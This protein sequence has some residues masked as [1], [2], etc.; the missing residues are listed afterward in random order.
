MK[1]NTRITLPYSLCLVLAM[2]AVFILVAAV[3]GGMAY[4]DSRAAR[5]ALAFEVLSDALS[6]AEAELAAQ[7]APAREHV[8]LA[9]RWI[10]QGTLARERV[11]NWS[12]LLLPPLEGRDGV[13]SLA[14][15]TDGGLLWQ[16][17]RRREGWSGRWSPDV[18]FEAPPAETTW[19]AFGRSLR[20]GAG[21]LSE[22]E[23]AYVSALQAFRDRKN[24][25]PDYIH[26]DAQ[27][28]ATGSERVFLAMD[29][30]SSLG[31]PGIIAM[32]LHIPRAVLSERAPEDGRI[33]WQ[34]DPGGKRLACLEESQTRE[35]LTNS[36]VPHHASLALRTLFPAPNGTTGPRWYGARA[37]AVGSDYRWWVVASVGE[38]ALP[39]PSLPVVHY[40]LVGFLVG[41]AGTVGVA[42]TMGW[43]ISRPLSL[44]ARRANGIQ[45]MDEHYLPW[46]NSRFTEVNQLTT[47]LEDLYETA[48]EHLDYHDA[49]LV[50]W[51]Q[52]EELSGT[53][54][55]V[56]AEP[57]K[58]HINLHANG[59]KVPQGADAPSGPVI[60]VSGEVGGVPAVPAA[61]LQ[62]LHG[63]RKEVRRLQSQLAGAYEELRT[64]DVHFQQGEARQKRQREALRELDRQLQ[65]E[66]AVTPETLRILQ[67]V[68]EARVVGFWRLQ[69]DREWFRLRL[70]TDDS[71]DETPLPNHVFLRALL[72]DELVVATRDLAGDPRFAPLREHPRWQHARGAMLLVPLKFGAHVLGFFAIEH[73]RLMG[74]WKGD[75]ETFASSCAIQ[76]TMVLGASLQIKN[77]LPVTPRPSAA[78]EEEG[79]GEGGE[80]EIRW[81]TDL[82]GCFKSIEGN[83]A[84]LLGYTARDLLGQPLTFLSETA[85]G[86]RDLAQLQQALSGAPCTGY[87]TT[88]RTGYGEEIRL[89]V[90]AEVQRDTAGR[91]A[92]IRGT[93]RPVAIPV[94]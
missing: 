80:E 50:V 81:E 3:V 91:V 65:R 52:E 18:D 20:H 55:V 51:G 37:Y 62:V 31:A 54:G 73:G 58:R 77:G 43:K 14:I 69:S 11:E 78:G 30:G 68:L 2:T 46:P 79:L 71:A 94:P 28:M 60:N 8:R 47:A 66:G 6:D 25:N 29:L 86:E 9:Q 42:T 38:S 21:E 32:E 1:R 39:E 88:L 7:I 53:E 57:L 93:A 4:R 40:G 72:Q 41:L 33:T 34:S 24:R 12:T 19:D 44:I 45:S 87:E 48:V 82:A 76:C 22:L 89:Y 35:L 23:G 16:A 36:A 17:S 26:V 90:M 5:S 61:Q 10:L 27:R 70:S 67:S 13:M 56:D 64:A 85:Q 84:A 59:D 92:G 83:V 49:P 15:V 75:E 63:S 74:V